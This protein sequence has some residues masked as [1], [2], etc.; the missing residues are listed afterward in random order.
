MWESPVLPKSN[1]IPH[2]LLRDNHY[3]EFSVSPSRIFKKYCTSM[4]L[5]LSDVYGFVCV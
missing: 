3:H 5:F 1:P 2:P 4:C